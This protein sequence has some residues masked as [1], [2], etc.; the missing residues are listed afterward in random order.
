MTALLVIF[1]LC[2][3][4][5]FVVGQGTSGTI[6]ASA[7]SVKSN[8]YYNQVFVNILNE[9]PVVYMQEISKLTDGECS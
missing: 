4:P 8:E 1:T 3:V 9:K 6:V 2:G 5:N 7:K